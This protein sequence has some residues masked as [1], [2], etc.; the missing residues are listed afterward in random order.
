MRTGGARGASPETLAPGDW[1]LV[2]A[3][4]R[5]AFME[6]N[7]AEVV[8]QIYAARRRCD[9]EAVLALCSAAFVYTCNFDPAKPAKGYSCVGRAS[10]LSNLR[11]I[12]DCW[13]VLSSE[14]LSVRVVPVKGHPESETSAEVTETV[15]CLIGYAMRHRASLGVI[16]GT[17]THEWTV[18]GGQIIALCETLDSNL[19]N[20]FLRMSDWSIRQCDDQAKKVPVASGEILK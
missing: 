18:R 8:R 17:K 15:R 13:E 19:L 1:D 20:A 9:N 6:R 4:I 14:V 2:I 5:G 7:S 3:V 10:N 12:D 11:L 16:E